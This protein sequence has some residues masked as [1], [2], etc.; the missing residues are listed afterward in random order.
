[1][2]QQQQNPRGCKQRD[3][4]R[5]ARR[6]GTAIC[7]IFSRISSGSSRN[8]GNVR[9][10][11]DFPFLLFLLFLLSFLE[12]ISTDLAGL[13]ALFYLVEEVDN[14]MLR[15]LGIRRH[16]G[17]H[18]WSLNFRSRE[19]LRGTYWH[20]TIRP[21]LTIDCDPMVEASEETSYIVLKLSILSSGHNHQVLLRVDDP[22][23]THPS[24]L[25]VHSIVGSINLT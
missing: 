10:A 16:A 24:R 25:F 20:M 4:M 14:M 2:S 5:M 19:C 3:L 9:A 17:F 11:C 22:K 8:L 15:L 7:Q 13:H 12:N 6:S 1:M 23:A 21:R 18:L